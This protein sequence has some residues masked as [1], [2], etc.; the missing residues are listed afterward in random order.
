MG[1]DLDSEE[2]EKVDLEETEVDSEEVEKV[3]LEEVEMV[4]SEEVDSEVTG[5]QVSPEE[6]TVL[7]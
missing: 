3:D 1:L 4:N 6:E 5:D 2:V 7:E